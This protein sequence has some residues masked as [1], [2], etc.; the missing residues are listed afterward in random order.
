M[1]KKL[2]IIV[3][4][5]GALITR[6]QNPHQPYTAEEVATEAV[7]AVKEGA[8]M[9]H[10]HCRYEDGL[11]DYRPETLKKALDRI[12]QDCPDVIAGPSISANPS[13]GAWLYEVETIRPF[14][15]ALKGYGSRYMESTVVTP[16]SYVSERARQV[17]GRVY[18]RR[19]T[20]ENLQAEVKY[21][22][23]KGIR[24]EFMGHDTVAIEQVK[25]WLIKPGI[26]EK[27]YFITLGPG[28]HHATP[29]YP[30]PWGLLH[31]I[32]M[33]YLLPEDAIVGASIGGRNWLPLAV[34]SII[35]GA[36]FIRVGMEDT[37]W[38]YPHRDESIIRNAEVVRK[39][40]CIARELGRDIMSPNEARKRLALPPP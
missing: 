2:G 30:D 21:L 4:P 27:P 3:C 28:M 26:L 37:M 40:A 6:E 23:G 35:L 18:I 38:M 15:E 32:S 11:P 29:T 22:Q 10:L 7:Q 36:D 8:C 33:R 31:L 5:T 39:T 13:E 17:A 1:D 19:A 20:E 25:E 12:F 9:V 14:V 24:P 16:I 34:L